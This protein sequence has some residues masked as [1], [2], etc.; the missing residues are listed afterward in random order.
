LGVERQYTSPAILQTEARIFAKL[1]TSGFTNPKPVALNV[2]LGCY[3]MTS[4]AVAPITGHA[5]YKAH[6]G[7]TSL[8]VVLRKE[9]T[10]LNVNDL[11]TISTD[12]P[13][14]GAKTIT[15]YT[16]ADQSA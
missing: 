1:G 5:N 3:H 15:S 16:L 10:T 8:T 4:L 9:T 7:T 11:I 6:S 13:N 14:C 12:V 2:Y